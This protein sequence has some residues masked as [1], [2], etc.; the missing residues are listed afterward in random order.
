VSG[1]GRLGLPS[2][3]YWVPHARPA[4][5]QI[6][7]EGGKAVGEALVGNSSLEWLYLSGQC[8]PESGT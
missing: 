1:R 7:V 3:V 2:S 6:G 4:E 8:L 5:N